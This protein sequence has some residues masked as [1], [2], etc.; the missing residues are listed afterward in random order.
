MDAIPCNMQTSTK[1]SGC[2]PYMYTTT[3]IITRQPPHAG[4]QT[5]L[6]L[7]ELPVVGSSHETP[8]TPSP[9]PVSPPLFPNVNTDL[10]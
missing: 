10:L 2:S 7:L 6:L 3:S 5:L 9:P 8:S 4:H 1:S